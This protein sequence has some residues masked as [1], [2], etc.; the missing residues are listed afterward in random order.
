MCYVCYCLAYT[1][2][3]LHSLYMY[4]VL[5]RVHVHARLYLIHSVC[6]VAVGTGFGRDFGLSDWDG[7]SAMV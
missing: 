3:A 6:V 7:A 4:F 5:L 1:A 2:H